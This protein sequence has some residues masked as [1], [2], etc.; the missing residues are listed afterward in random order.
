MPL[1][2][3]EWIQRNIRNYGKV[4]E[5]VPEG[6]TPKNFVAYFL[7]GDGLTEPRLPEILNMHKSLMPDM[8]TQTF[9]CGVNYENAPIL[10]HP[11]LDW[12]CVTLSAPNSEVYKKVHR[13]DKFFNVM[14]TM[15]YIT[16]HRHKRQKLE[17]H[18]VITEANIGSMRE[19]YDM[20]LREFPE[21]T[22]VFSPLVKSY[23]NEPSVRAMGKLTLEQE[24]QAILDNAGNQA[25]FWKHDTTA[26]RQPCVL[27]NNCAIDVEGYILQCCN[28]ADPKKWNYGTVQQYIDEGRNLRDY[29]LERLANKMRNPLCENC[30]LKHPNWRKRLDDIHMRASVSSL[31]SL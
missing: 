8:W 20:I 13:G 5:K 30:N 29:W 10:V 14:K 11:L 18:F 17:V 12:V 21:W 16:E 6:R 3:I 26:L 19:W 27:W 23:D 7:N 4:D 9:T 15:R 31:E 24:E 28:W 1:E 22:P 2:W 25:K